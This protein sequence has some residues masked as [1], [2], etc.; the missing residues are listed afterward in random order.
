MASDPILA[1]RGLTDEEDR[2]LSADLPLAEL[3]ER[4]GGQIPGKLAIPELLDLVRQ[5]R[6]M[7]LRLAR[8]FSAFD[9]E[10]IVTGF[11]RINPLSGEDH[12]AV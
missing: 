10:S 2:L 9:G 5:G 8:D 11:V 3:Q 4:C 1:A 12:G 7:G 6:E